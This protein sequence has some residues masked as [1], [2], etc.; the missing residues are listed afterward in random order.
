M[1][2]LPAGTDRNTLVVVRARDVPE[3][4]DPSNVP[5][6]IVGAAWLEAFPEDFDFVRFDGE[7]DEQATARE[8]AALAAAAATEAQT[9][10]P[11]TQA[12]VRTD[13][14]A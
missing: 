4:T 9:K 8:E 7:T 14:F 12:P 3:G 1:A 5:E 2:D 11:K 6:Y 13:S 10:P